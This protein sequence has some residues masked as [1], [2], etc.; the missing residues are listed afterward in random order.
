MTILLWVLAGFVIYSLIVL[1]FTR[2]ALKKEDGKF[3]IKK[4]NF[5][6]F[7]FYKNKKMLSDSDNNGFYP[8]SFFPQNRCK[9]YAG[10][11]RGIPW[12]FLTCFATG[13][14]LSLLFSIG[15]IV[16]FMA[17]Y[18]PTPI[19]FMK[20]ENYAD[21]FKKM[22]WVAPWKIILPV[23][24][25]VGIVI[26][27]RGIWEVLV[28]I[29]ETL[30]VPRVGGVFVACAVCCLVLLLVVGL[31]KNVV[32]ALASFIKKYCKEIEVED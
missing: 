24:L 13:L 15:T 26:F 21:P 2:L 23:G 29:P 22:K 32:G 16:A 30:G 8:D 31:C 19:R 7:Y 1:V 5:F 4:D 14:F 25:I 18:L 10:I 3:K 12:K 17:G 9:L 27:H 6:I 20:T 11:Y 28:K